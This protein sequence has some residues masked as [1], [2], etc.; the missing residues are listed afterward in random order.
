MIRRWLR[1]AILAL[2]A[3]ITGLLALPAAATTTV[4]AAYGSA[5]AARHEGAR[6]RPWI[7]ITS[8]TPGYETTNGKV[9]ISGIVTN[10]TGAQ[11]RG[12]SIQL[13][14]LPVSLI[15]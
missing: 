1:L 2:V 3:G 4:S 6:D 9:T 14:S 13:Y 5:A 12:Y 7:A 15:C 8:M 11:L 10:P